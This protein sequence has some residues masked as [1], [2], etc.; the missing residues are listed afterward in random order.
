MR[1][2]PFPEGTIAP[3]CA[4]S[5]DV[6]AYRLAVGR[7]AR[8]FHSARSAGPLT[9]G[10]RALWRRSSRILSFARSPGPGVLVSEATPHDIQEIGGRYAIERELGQGGTSTVYLAHDRVYDRRVAV[11]VLRRELAV[12]L[13]ADRFLREIRVTARLNHPH[14]APV[15]DSGV[16]DGVCYFVTTYLDGGTLRERLEG[17]RQ[18]PVDEAI[19]LTRAVASALDHAHAQGVLHCDVKPENILFSNGEAFLTD[20]GIARLFE[21]GHEGTTS[22]GIVRGT[23]AYM[24]PEQAG[25]EKGYD[26]RT[27]VYSLA[28]VLYE[29]LAGV[30]AF[31]AATPQAVLAQRFLHA[32]RDLR[33]YRPTVPRHVEAAIARA[34]S[35][36]PD[37]RFAT[38]GEFVRAL[39]ER[40]EP[41]PVRNGAQ[42]PNAPESVA[43]VE[44][45]VPSRPPWVSRQALALGVA[46]VAAIVS[47][48]A[49][50][51]RGDGRLFGDRRT[52][53]VA[54][55]T[56]PT[57]VFPF[58]RDSV[59]DTF[60]GEDVYL[61]DALARWRGLRVI[62]TPR[63]RALYAQRDSSRFGIAD[64][65][66][67]AREA[68][69]RRFIWGRVVDRGGAP[70]LVASMYDVR[71]TNEPVRT[72]SVPIP[73]ELVRDSVF[74]Y[75]ASALA[76]GSSRSLGETGLAGTRSAPARAAYS[77][78]LAAVKEWNLSG[79]DSALV[80]ALDADRDYSQ[81]L[82]LR[83]QISGWLGDSS[84]GWRELAAA[85]VQRESFLGAR[86]RALARATYFLSSR[87][88]QKACPIY[89]QLAA[90][91]A[92]EFTAWFGLAE[93]LRRDESVVQDSSSASGWRF[94]TS[95]GEAIRAY[96]HAFGLLPTVSRAYKSHGF[97]RLQS[98]LRTRTA[99]L[100]HGQSEKTGERFAA[101]PSWSGDSLAFVPYPL[102]LVNSSRSQLSPA[103]TLQAI[104]ENRRL[105]LRVTERWA[106]EL[107]SDATSLHA[108]AIAQDLQGDRSSVGT[109]KRAL[110]LATPNERLVLTAYLAWM[111]VKHACG[112]IDRVEPDTAVLASARRLADSV[113]RAAPQT[114]ADE[115]VPALTG[116]AAL[117]GQSAYG[118]ELVRRQSHP[119]VAYLAGR[120]VTVAGRVNGLSAAFLFYAAIG[121]PVDSIVALAQRAEAGIRS[122]L[123]EDV[124]DDARQLLFT[125]AI[126]LAFPTAGRVVTLNERARQDYLL[127]A[128]DAFKVN[129]ARR[130]RELLQEVRAARRHLRPGDLRFD[131]L[132]PEAWMLA[133][134][135]D[136]GE[137]LS[138]ISP[139]LDAV[140]G[141]A[142]E[143]I[144]NPAN[145]A[146]LVRG[147]ALRAELATDAR[148][149]RTAEFWDACFS[150][151]WPQVKVSSR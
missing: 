17:D 48:G 136:R 40:H 132:Y 44:V 128:E 74:D 54:F 39:L 14:I 103:S 96:E 143:L 1:G 9:V 131:S 10:D 105:L 53:G 35:L 58:A 83:A 114:V 150:T 125:Q 68:G 55:D 109:L 129:D 84:A 108:L 3:V 2:G 110:S 63:A 141:M 90:T 113:L 8:R 102:A 61:H 101:Y 97:V 107:P 77:R 27:D 45:A 34:M 16:G 106:R 81:A 100:R 65:R 134:I 30:P 145:I 42:L 119:T 116:L 121:G 80:E 6:V 13:G 52:D 117:T 15:I 142:P 57:I 69:A 98:L 41:T 24:S 88:F 67:L 146:A 148:D 60:T 64:A 23:P 92:N 104:E 123:S 137:A 76:F 138:W 86:D 62:E 31:V 38:A 151:L 47:F 144:E 93:C 78:A 7:P 94:S 122:D 82:L 43:S 36:S 28:C 4:P 59:R 26:G 126:A 127:A 11:K 72:A 21:A 135:G 5:Y 124:Q 25:G 133:R 66:R 140:A 19:S 91:D 33:V 37:D 46:G 85:A 50:V 70:T 149:L 115:D 22:T 18:L 51:M 87:Q 71:G 112:E 12:S 99:L 89:R 118:A 75:L 32:P 20:F 79:A 29:A 95:Y 49:W 73:V 147:M 120:P 56:A 139:S 111:Q 130:V